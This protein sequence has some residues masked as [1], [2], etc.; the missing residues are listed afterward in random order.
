MLKN[1]FRLCRV[2]NLLS[3]ITENA[4][5][6]TTR[7]LWEYLKCLDCISMN[8]RTYAQTYGC[9]QPRMWTN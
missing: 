4:Y 2:K 5:Q 8:I 3:I 1:A 7:L 9:V 6:C